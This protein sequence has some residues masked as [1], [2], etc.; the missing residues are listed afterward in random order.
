MPDH[1]D[2][3]RQELPNVVA[4]ENN[5]LEQARNHRRLVFLVINQ[6]VNF[7]I[8]PLPVA[9]DAGQ[10]EGDESPA[11]QRSLAGEPWICSCRA[12]QMNCSA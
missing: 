5:V 3:F 10:G 1:G 9:S 11:A 2:Q 8:N 4:V 7:C 12:L 6:Q